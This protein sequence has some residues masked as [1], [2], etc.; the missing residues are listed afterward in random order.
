MTASGGQRQGD[1]RNRIAFTDE[2]KINGK[3]EERQR[4]AKPSR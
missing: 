1:E 3:W 2:S 4:L